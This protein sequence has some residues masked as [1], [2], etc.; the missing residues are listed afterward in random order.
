MTTPNR[1]TARISPAPSVSPV[2]PDGDSEV[3]RA[4]YTKGGYTPGMF[5]DV[6]SVDCF[7]KIL[8]VPVPAIALIVPRDTPCKAN[9]CPHDAIEGN[10]GYCP[11]HRRAWYP[12]LNQRGEDLLGP[13]FLSFAGKYRVC[14]CS[15]KSC[16]SAGY[17]PHQDALYIP[18]TGHKT[19]LNT[20]NLL[21][22]ATKN[23]INEKKKSWIRLY[24]WHFFPE[25]RAREEGGKWKLNYN[26]KETVKFYDLERR[27]YDFP[28][29]RN[30][31]NNFLR[32]EYFSSYTRPQERWA[33]Q[34]VVSKMPAWMLNMLAIDGHSNIS[35][36][37]TDDVSISC[38]IRQVE[39]WK[40]RAFHLDKQKKELAELHTHQIEGQKRKYEDMMATT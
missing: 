17:F 18:V 7:A 2:P 15:Q 38:L 4:R 1:H 28:P 40:A 9:G 37:N 25:H 35:P 12:L 19:V 36:N 14:D 11:A 39:Q 23:K 21:S 13:E 8:G 10:C 27:A 16:I 6:D 20:P 30:T 34:N 29:P 5:N 22:A 26:R 33:A 24:P 32:D 31:P 3:G